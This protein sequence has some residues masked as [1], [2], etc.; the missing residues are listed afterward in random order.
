MLR[1]GLEAN[2]QARTRVYFASHIE[3]FHERIMLAGALINEEHLTAI[4][5]ECYLANG[6]DLNYLL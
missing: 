6:P 5:D 3:R 2:G 4:L 1:A